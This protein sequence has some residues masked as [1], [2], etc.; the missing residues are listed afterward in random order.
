MQNT[1][2]FMPYDGPICPEC[3]D[4]IDICGGHPTTATTIAI[5]TRDLEGFYHREIIV[6]GSHH[7]VVQRVAAN[8]IA[9]VLDR[10]ANEVI[11]YVPTSER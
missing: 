1:E 2:G 3:G 11:I 5:E 6:P 4:G 10:T 8:A 7:S 9:K